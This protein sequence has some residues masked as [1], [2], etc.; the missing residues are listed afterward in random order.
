MTIKETTPATPS[1][2]TPGPWRLDGPYQIPIDAAPPNYVE[3]FMVMNADER[4]GHSFPVARVTG[5]AYAGREDECDPELRANA[6][7]I[8]RACNSH[9]DLLD[10]A[11]R[12][13]GFIRAWEKQEGIQ[14]PTETHDF[15]NKVLAK[16]H[17][18]A[19]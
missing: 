19:A 10:V 17:G 11:N 5:P 8:V 12:F 16:A 3:G 6:E 1:A 15:I 14:E 18:V 2:H 13:L 7:F 4:F 9:E